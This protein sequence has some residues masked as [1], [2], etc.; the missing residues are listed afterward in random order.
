MDTIKTVSQFE[1][2]QTVIGFFLVRGMT[3]KT[4]AKT[5]KVYG[6][7]ILADQTGE[8]SAKLWEV[9]DP[10]ACP[11]VGSFLKV[12]GL[13]TEYQGKL[14]FRMDR[15][16]PVTEDDPVDIGKMVP[17]APENSHAMLN[18][19]LAKV[20]TIRDEGLNRLLHAALDAAGDRLLYYPAALRNHHAIRSGLLYHTLTML[21]MGEN[22][23]AIYP[24][25]NRDLLLTGVILHDMEKLEELEAS[26]T[27]ISTGYSVIGNLVGHI[28][29]GVTWVAKLAEKVNLDPERTMLLQHMLLAHHDNPEYGSPKRPMFAEA[30]ALHELDLLDAR[31]YDFQK[32]EGGLKPGEFSDPV[33]SLENRKLYR[34]KL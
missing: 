22:V 12:Q 20:D 30:E 34:P 24:F 26:E 28:N 6:D 16:R 9:A 4:S 18:E 19:L 29:L 33:W 23:L 2:G 10:A 17:S 14:Q 13:V 1:A 3:I 11:D 15:F 27:G 5:N 21:R 8:I 7:Y 25:L 32:I 31:M